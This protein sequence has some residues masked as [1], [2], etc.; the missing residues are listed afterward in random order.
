[1]T[2]TRYTTFIANTRIGALFKQ[3]APL[4]GTQMQRIAHGAARQ[5]ERCGSNMK[6]AYLIIAHNN[7]K[8]L[9]RLINALSSESSAFFVH[10]GHESNMDDFS[11]INGK[12][13]YFCENRIRCYWG[14]FSIVRTVLMLIQTAFTDDRHFNYFLLLSG[15]DY[16]VQPTSYIET[17]FR[18]HNGT[19]FIDVVQMPNEEEGRLIWR[20]TSYKPEPNGLRTARILRRMLVKTGLIPRCAPSP[21]APEAI[22]LYGERNYKA[23]LCG[24]TPYGGH[25]WWALSREAC[26]Y[27]LNFVDEN[28][29]IVNFFKHTHIPDESFFQTILGNSPFR[30]KIQRCLT[31]ANWE[32]GGPHPSLISEKDLELF[33]VAGPII[34]SQYVNRDLDPS[35]VKR[36]DAYGTGEILFARKF[37]DDAEEMVAQMDQIIR[38]KEKRL[39]DY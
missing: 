24:L 21:F 10:I 19:E 3:E 28:P 4:A 25:A 18:R 13:V 9:Q 27:I 29:R 14:D 33:K 35:G 15:T 39:A 32:A 26:N 36:S 38:E 17:F 8:H 11:G 34:I 6:I 5:R 1:V 2:R 16:P 20:L 37:S 12:N 23:H 30:S 31:Y 22:T 7:P